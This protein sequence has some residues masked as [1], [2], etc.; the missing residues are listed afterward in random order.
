MMETVLYIFVL[1]VV[2]HLIAAAIIFIAVHAAE[3]KQL[4]AELTARDR[5][6]QQ[7]DARI[8]AIRAK[9]E[10]EYYARK[11]AAAA[12][13]VMPLVDPQDFKR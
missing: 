11:R 5:W 2:L 6:L 10:A 7:E 12:T 8:E 1:L 13:T 9:G 4:K 3:K